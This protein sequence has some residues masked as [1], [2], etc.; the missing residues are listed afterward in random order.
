MIGVIT[1]TVFFSKQSVLECADCKET[2][3]SG[4]EVC[5]L[6]SRGEH[7]NLKTRKLGKIMI[8]H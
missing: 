4:S 6:L 1:V 5:V 8:D 2:L 3:D 7:P